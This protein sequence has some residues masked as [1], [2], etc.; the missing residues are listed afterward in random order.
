MPAIVF[1]FAAMGRSYMI[2]PSTSAEGS[3]RSGGEPTCVPLAGP[4]REKSS[5][6]A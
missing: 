3:L 1:L 2:F 4:A 5:K 6:L